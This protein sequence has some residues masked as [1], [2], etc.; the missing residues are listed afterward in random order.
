MLIL[1]PCKDQFLL[2]LLNFSQFS[3]DIICF[4]SSRLGD[5][6]QKYD[7]KKTKQNKKEKTTTTES[8]LIAQKEHCIW[9]H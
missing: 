5:N 8:N 6:D 9:N 3:C 4:V 2:T 1:V 7:L